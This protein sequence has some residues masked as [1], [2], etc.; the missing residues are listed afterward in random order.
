MKRIFHYTT[1]CMGIFCSAVSCS[2]SNPGEGDHDKLI[3]LAISKET[4]D[5]TVGETFDLAVEGTP[6][7]ASLENLRWSSENTATAKCE[8]GAVT[9]VAAGTATIKAICDGIT[10][11]C[12]V[13]VRPAPIALKSITISPSA[14]T[15]PKSGTQ[16]LTAVLSP[17]GTAA[18]PD[19]IVWDSSN[20]AA[21][22]VDQNGC[23][24]A[25]SDGLTTV[26][27][28]I[29]TVTGSCNVEVYTKTASRTF[30]FF[31][32][33]L[34]EGLANVAGGTQSLIDQLVALKPDAASFCE[35]PSTGSAE[36]ILSAAATA[37]YEQTGIPYYYNYLGGSGTRGLLTRHPI[38]STGMVNN[39]GWFYCT[40]I[41][42]YGQEIALYASHSYYSY[43]ACYLPRGYGD[44][45]QPYGWSKISTGPI[46]DV[47][48]ILQRE[49][50]S[51]RTRI[52]DD[53][54]ADAKIQGEA[55]RL[56]IFGG[57]LNQ[58]SHLD[59]TDA[60]KNMF[61]H[62]GCV[63]AWPVSTKCYAN[64]IRDAYRE[65]YPDPVAHPGV[66]WPVSNKDA[67]KA[68]PW[69]ADA[70][71]RDRIDYVYYRVDTNIE[72]Q[73]AQMAGPST[74]MAKGVAVED[75]F[76]NK[77]EE[78]ILPA[79]GKWPSDHRGLFVTFSVKFR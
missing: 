15:V 18:S 12:E 20:K 44:G 52:A 37:L 6:S 60:A 59:W 27:A 46:T 69:T 68:T 33:N 51:G 64:G 34:W 10:A 61:E 13:T 66:T 40:V 3:S 42:F 74:M 26:T 43:Y 5:L 67:S 16:N 38:I 22:T 31:Q 62:N 17:E 76:V 47:E 56:C 55:G 7:T 63:V 28:T 65:I 14:V 9:A 19:D 39:S 79:N 36:N 29:G 71:E 8:D 24:T 75:T 25:V 41:D 58:P 77:A 78:L 1:L 23:I 11:A 53:F 45:E 30:T 32:L 49:E 50:L 54:T 2:G 57:D 21:A 72:V 4:L 35:F 73:K 48:F 70:D